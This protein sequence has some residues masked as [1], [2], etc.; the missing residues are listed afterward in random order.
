PRAGVVVR[1]EPGGSIAGLVVNGSGK[2]VAAAE[3]SVANKTVTTGVDG[4]F[5]AHGFPP[6][7]Y[8][9][10]AA[11]AS[12]GSPSQTIKLERGGH[13]ELTLT[14]EPSR[15]AGVVVDPHGAPIESARVSAYSDDS[16]G[17]GFALT[18]EHGRFDFG[19]LPPGNYAVS[20]HRDDEEGPDV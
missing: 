15:I 17:M 2:P 3:V 11:T 7:D 10:S 9:V 6:D 20:A 1:V 4:R 5:V 8:T 19:G 16:H 13:A 14:V 18:D 12:A